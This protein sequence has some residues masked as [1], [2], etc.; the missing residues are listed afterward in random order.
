M[1]FHDQVKCGALL[2]TRGYKRVMTDLEIKIQ[3]RSIVMNIYKISAKSGIITSLFIVGGC[4]KDA[5][6]P[7]EATQAT[8]GKAEVK[9]AK[10]KSIDPEVVIAAYQAS[11]ASLGLRDESFPEQR[12]YLHLDEPTEVLYRVT[13][14]GLD[15]KLL[16]EV[17]PIRKRPSGPGLRLIE[18]TIY[19]DETLW[20]EALSTFADSDPT[21]GATQEAR[22]QEIHEAFARE[23]KAAQK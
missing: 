11:A 21:D 4:G 6:A 23:L 2:F 9:K 10:G 13:V 1:I 5:E 8:S 15:R 19:A 22:I 14:H 20:V 12:L 3:C 7:G 18:S 16:P 17:G